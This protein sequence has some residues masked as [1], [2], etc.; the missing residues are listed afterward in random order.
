MNPETVNAWIGF[1]SAVV[2]ALVGAYGG[3]GLIRRS[4]A[5][6]LDST[7]DVQKDGIALHATDPNAWV[8]IVT[9]DAAEARDDA[10]RAR[11]EATE[12]RAESARLRA[13]F[14]QRDRDDR[15][16]AIALNRW[17]TAIARAWGLE[18]EMP[19]PEEGDREVLADVIPTMLE[20][21]RPTRPRR[22]KE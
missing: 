10:R 13:A 2:V 1:A 11:E 20:A 9:K 17:L 21:T 4:K 3:R 5:K 18:P 12:A 14:D 15:R 19:Y 7:D 22:P 6:R 16:R 8:A